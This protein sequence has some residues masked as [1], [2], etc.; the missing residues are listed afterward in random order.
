MYFFPQADYTYIQQYTVVLLLLEDLPNGWHNMRKKRSSVVCVCVYICIEVWLQP[1]TT[2]VAPPPPTCQVVSFPHLRDER[3]NQKDRMY[4]SESREPSQ[5]REQSMAA[6]MAARAYL[7]QEFIK[8][9]LQ[10]IDS[11]GKVQLFREGHKNVSNCPYGFKIYLVNVKTMRMIAQ[12][13]VA[14]SEKLNFT[15]KF[16]FNYKKGQKYLAMQ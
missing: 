14:F 16:R 1:T 7:F 3:Q 10:E 9:N 13:F 11:N 12:I 6:S 4:K 2:V 5:E 15:F 8:Q